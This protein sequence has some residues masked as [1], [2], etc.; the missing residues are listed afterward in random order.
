MKKSVFSKGVVKFSIGFLSAYT[1]VSVVTL[2][3]TGE[4]L[5]DELTKWVFLFFGVEILTLGGVKVA[6]VLKGE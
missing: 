1:V 2:F 4:S 3:V 5:P 6:K